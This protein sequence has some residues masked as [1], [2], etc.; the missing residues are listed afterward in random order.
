MWDSHERH[1]PGLEP[2]LPALMDQ[3]V[4]RARRAVLDDGAF[5]RRFRALQRR[6]DG[7]HERLPL[8]VS[9]PLT[10]V[11][12]LAWLSR[13]P[14]GHRLYWSSRD[15]YRELAAS[16]ASLRVERDAAGDV[17]G[18]YDRM[19][20]ILEAADDDDAVFLGGQAFAPGGPVDDLWAGF[21][22]LAYAVPDTLVYRRGSTA[23]LILCAAID[24]RSREDDVREALL[25][26]L[27]AVAPT[28]GDTKPA[29]SAT[30]TRRVDLPGP[31]DW[32]AAVTDTLASVARGD[33]SK[34]V[35]A[36][37][38]Q[39]DCTT[40]VDPVAG[41][42]RLARAAPRSFAYLVERR[43][44]TAFLGA[45]P[46]RLFRLTGTRLETEAIA[47]TA[48]AD[49]AQ[50]L[51]TCDKNGREHRLVLDHLIERLSRLC[52]R[53]DEPQTRR[54][55]TLRDVSH[56]AAGLQGDLAPGRTLGDVV[57]ALH[58][59]PAVCGTST[60]AALAR[61]RRHEPFGRGWYAGAVG[62]VDRRGAELAVA[63]RSALVGGNRLLA[64][65]GAGIVAG[66]EPD[67]EWRELESKIRPVLDTFAGA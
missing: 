36:R 26:R 62:V 41:L 23:S 59:T 34:V 1:D 15:G 52:S 13:Q 5:Y 47:G 50:G 12:P 49:A 7:R 53:M 40:D 42:E 55:L 35:L 16:G 56:L 9:A 61:I 46:E 67:Q 21:P 6:L 20:G 2:R 18:A 32:A 65:A 48:P 3:D 33:V 24:A 11:R 29:R 58:P 39:L 17:G 14:A 57:A 64:F 25:A 60:E 45:S 38:T 43:P 51:F 28:G 10:D 66:S 22:A 27:A 19:A 37:R 30:C 63:I 8:T 54:L 4:G 44:G 31:A